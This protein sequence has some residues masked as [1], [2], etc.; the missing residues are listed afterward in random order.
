MRDFIIK[1]FQKKLLSKVPLTDQINFKKKFLKGHFKNF[2]KEALDFNK[3]GFCCLKIEDPKWLTYIDQAKDDLK[4]F[5]D[6][7]SFKSG[8]SKKDRIQD[9]WQN[10][11]LQSVKKIACHPTILEALKTIYGRKPFPFQTLNFSSGSEQHFHSDAVHFNSD[12]EGFM[13]GAW[14]ALEDISQES[15]PLIYYPG[16]HRLPYLDAQTLNLNIEEL[17]KEKHPQIFFDKLWEDL[18]KENK[19]KKS[20]YLPKK[21]DVLIWHA[22]LIHGGSKVL[23]HS[24]SRWSQVTHYYFEHCKYYTPFFKAIGA[25][26]EDFKRVPANLLL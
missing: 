21:G 26:K 18:V 20:I 1:F 25:T 9:A 5:M 2:S 17:K 10:K 6:S 7:D 8:K 13:C 4:S 19:F 22:N 24:K 12:P 23:D 14:V 3:F 16:S 15:G 11:N